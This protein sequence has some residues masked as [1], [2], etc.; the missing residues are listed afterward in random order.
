MSRLCIHQK[1]TALKRNDEGGALVEFGLLL[2]T[3]LLF[4]AMAI[5]GSRF[6][7]SYQSAI[8]GMRDASRYVGRSAPSDICQT[9]GDLS[10]YSAVVRNIVQQTSSGKSLFPNSIQIT[11]VETDLNCVTGAY[12]LTETP[13]ATIRVNM[14]IDYPFASIFSLVGFDLDTMTTSVT[15]STRVFGA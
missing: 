15:D 12:R 9:G 11:S 1:M 7:W 3:M 14:R 13:I 10:G 5:E 2:P 6:F 8:A 4:F